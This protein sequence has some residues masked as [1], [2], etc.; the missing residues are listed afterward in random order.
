MAKV[1]DYEVKEELYYC[2]EHFWAK[3]DGDI[4]R[5]GTTDYGQKALREIVYVELP[6]VGAEV[7]QGEA[8][9]TIESVKAVVDLIAPVSGIIETVNESLRDSPEAINSD[10]YGEGWLITIKSS[11]LQEELKDLMDFD[12]AKTFHE[13]IIKKR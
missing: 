10:P 6:A 12:S 4:V 7:K 2:K 5:T 1:G 11:N 3:I 9:G 13:E 8:Y